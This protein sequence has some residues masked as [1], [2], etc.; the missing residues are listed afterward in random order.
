MTQGQG[1]QRR[2]FTTLVKHRTVREGGGIEP[3]VSLPAAPPSEIEIQ[4]QDQETY[5]NFAS[6]FQKK[7]P[8]APPS[9]D[10]PKG[11]VVGA[12]PAAPS[13]SIAVDDTVFN[14][15]LDFVE[16]K[17]DS[18]FEARTRFDPYLKQLAAA[19]KKE[20]LEAMAA[21]TQGLTQS[22]QSTLRQGFSLS[23]WRAPCCVWMGARSKERSGEMR[24]AADPPTPRSP[25]AAPAR[26]LARRNGTPGVFTVSCPPAPHA[27]LAPDG[28]S[29]VTADML[30]HAVPIKRRLQEALLTRQ[31]PESLR[32]ARSLLDD[33]VAQQAAKLVQDDTLY[34]SLLQEGV[35]VNGEP[36]K[37]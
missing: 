6:F 19:M 17:D 23:F 30:A 5:E 33:D 3:D 18:G 29:A 37:R 24:Q 21:Q 36:A 12:R 20:G 26:A 2:S 13:G 25:A 4:L 35:V 14:A 27:P 1:P 9:N 15:F 28:D 11:V 31:E 10:V 22:A 8:L 7:N 34:N 32:L 16:R